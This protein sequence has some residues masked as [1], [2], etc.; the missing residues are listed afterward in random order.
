M[1]EVVNSETVATDRLAA[2]AIRGSVAAVAIR[3]GVNREAAEG[4]IAVVRVPA[5]AIDASSL[6]SP[7]EPPS[8]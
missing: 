1:I 5:V 6:R 3:H 8:T 2:V 7:A 4:D